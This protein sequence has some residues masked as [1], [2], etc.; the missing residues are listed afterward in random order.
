MWDSPGLL[1]SELLDRLSSAIESRS[2]HWF[3]Y[4]A[5]LFRRGI[6]HPLFISIMNAVALAEERLPGLSEL[7]VTRIG[8]TG[9]RERDDRDYEQLLQVLAELS[10]VTQVVTSPWPAGTVFRLEPTAPGSE[11]GPEVSI[12]GPAG[13][14]GIEVKAPGLLAHQRLRA[15]NPLQATSRGGVIGRG[16]DVTLPRD[17]PMKD[18]LIGADEKFAGF[19]AADP[20]FLGVLVVVWDDH[21]YEPITALLHPNSGLL[22]E[23][24]FHRE[25]GQAV[26]YPNVD[27]VVLVRQLHQ[28]AAAA[29][30]RPL[31]D[32]RRHALDYG[33]PG[34]PFKVV[35]PPAAI[36]RLP[37]ELI[38]ALHLR[39]LD[40][41]MG[42]EYG[43]SDGVF[44]LG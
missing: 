39:A 23:N 24:S 30:D 1:G 21:V 28:I 13:L 15:A 38:R 5:G 11:K 42:A 3:A 16:A 2:W 35:I 40:V 31:P 44:W 29:G 26:T 25:D 27:A 19:K 20:S 4:H 22:T 34:Y 14:I 33:G 8:T 41:R 32:G 36:E 17:N 10:V 7:V 43:V 37:E 18:F 12:E 9:G 6:V